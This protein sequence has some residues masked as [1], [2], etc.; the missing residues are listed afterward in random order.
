MVIVC[1]N[2]LALVLIIDVRH[3]RKTSASVDDSSDHI[4]AVVVTE[5]FILPEIA[6]FQVQLRQL[7]VLVSTLEKRR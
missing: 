3:A 2:V 1:V 6:H 4:A 5:A 7:S